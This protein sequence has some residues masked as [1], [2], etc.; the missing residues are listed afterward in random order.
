MRFMTSA[1]P[2]REIMASRYAAGQGKETFVLLHTDKFKPELMYLLNTAIVCT[3][4]ELLVELN[5]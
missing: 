2:R 3:M 4:Q 1:I 5:Q